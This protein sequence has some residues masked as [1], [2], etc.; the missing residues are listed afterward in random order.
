MLIALLLACSAE[1]TQTPAA[2]TDGLRVVAPLEQDDFASLVGLMRRNRCTHGTKDQCVMLHY[3]VT[4]DRTDYV[5]AGVATNVDIGKTVA[6]G[7]V[8]VTMKMNGQLWWIH[9]DRPLAAGLD[10]L[11]CGRDAPCMAF[12]DGPDLRVWTP[13][14]ESTFEMPTD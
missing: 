11:G 7:K 13:M 10:R 5:F 12:L 6:L 8:D 1:P 14:S 9:P 3:G 4:A 2:T